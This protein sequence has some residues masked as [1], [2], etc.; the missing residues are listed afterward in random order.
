MSDTICMFCGRGIDH[1]PDERCAKWFPA[2]KSGP[3]AGT[4]DPIGDIQAMWK[5]MI[6]RPPYPDPPLDPAYVAYARAFVD[7]ILRDREWGATDAAA[8]EEDG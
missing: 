7:G 1:E 5:Q 2:W 4:R 8:A 6:N 3:P